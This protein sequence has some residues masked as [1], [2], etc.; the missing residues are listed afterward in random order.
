MILDKNGKETIELQIGDIVV[1]HNADN[2]PKGFQIMKINNKT[3]YVN[4]LQSEKKFVSS[5]LNTDKH[6]FIFEKDK[7]DKSMGDLKYYF[8][9]S[10]E[11]IL[12]KNNL[13]KY[14]DYISQIYL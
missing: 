11:S 3:I 12:S 2:D 8:C 14:S 10:K 6:L 4:L 1:F 7:F 9:G 5:N 13:I